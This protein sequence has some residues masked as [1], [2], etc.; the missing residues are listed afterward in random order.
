MLTYL[1]IKD[2]AVVEDAAIEPGAGLVAF[3]GETGAGKSVILGGLELV[4]GR[5]ASLD[6]V[7]A[8]AEEAVVEAAFEPAARDDLTRLLEEEGLPP[9]RDQLVVRRRLS[10]AGSRAWVNGSLVPVGTLARIGALLVDIV[11]QHESQALLVPGAQLRLL[12]RSGNLEELTADVAAAWDRAVAVQ[13]QLER[14]RADDR[15]RA[16]RADFLRFQIQEIRAAD[17][18]EGEEDEAAAERGRL[19]H[20]EELG[21]HAREGLALLYESEAAAA[22]LLGQAERHL[23]AI[24]AMDVAHGLPI[25][26]LR[27]ARFAVEEAGRSLQAYLDAVHSDPARLAAIEDRLAEID[28]LRRKYGDT[29]AEVLERA[30]EAEAELERL[31]GRDAELQRLAQD[32]DGALENYDAV[33]RR[34]SGAREKA[35]AAMQSRITE[36]LQSL[37]MEGARL[38]IHLIAAD[39][40]DAPGLP[41]GGTRSG[42][43]GVEFRLAANP[44]QPERPLARVASGGE[45]SRVLLA[46]KL[47][48]L[49]SGPG[50]TLVFDEIDAGVGGGRVAERLA[51][52]LEQLAQEHQVLVVTHLPQIAAR[53][54]SQVL[55]SKATESDRTRVGMTELDESSRVDE[56]A[57]MLGGVEITGTLR[58][59]A[60]ALLRR[61]E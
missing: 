51:A 36:E 45:M 4:I 30:G 34:L 48:A 61:E 54:R 50:Q 24:A 7:R 11:G 22:T 33:A 55:V 35:A 23:E 21:Q 14:L 39:G 37:G 49:G 18:T 43:E 1:R 19:R 3:T 57:R 25:E 2:L 42:Y 40:S 5:R 58:E 17:L 28:A 38:A 53:A 32:L 29:V 6:Q 13:A 9:V 8:G 27:E 31:E 44:G 56:L 41:P 16:Q 10:A 20:S 52:R 26:G 15:E 12:D 60:R 59:H 47:A 46:L